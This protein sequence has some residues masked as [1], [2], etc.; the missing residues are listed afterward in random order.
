MSEKLGNF[1]R[2]VSNW[3]WDQFIKAESDMSYTSNEAII[4]SLIRSCAMQK[5]DAIKMSMNRLDGK[6]KT[7]VIIETPKVFYVYPNAKL[8][9][10]HVSIV[11]VDGSQLSNY[12][13]N[14][15]LL[16]VRGS[17]DELLV[18]SPEDITDAIIPLQGKP[19]GD[20][21]S[22]SLRETLAEMAK[23]PRKLPQGIIMLAEE[24]QRW[25]QGQ[26]AM[27]PEIPKV[28]SVV[29]AH[30]LNMAHNRNIS[31]LNEVFDQLDGKLTEVI[32]IIG[33]D[34]YITNYASVAPDNATPN[35]A[36]VLQ[37]EATQV[38]ALWAAKLGGQIG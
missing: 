14:D 20:L 2:E 16:L 36:G 23:C 28:K 15:T 25:V 5:L 12:G 30:L 26:G 22:M 4:F 1:L 10:P 21:P 6:L 33:E 32:K 7:P 27:P 35:K 8:E 18:P 31:A 24:T 38:Q 9:A 29:A 11:S 3:D 37:V 13:P 34:I 19:V 17:D